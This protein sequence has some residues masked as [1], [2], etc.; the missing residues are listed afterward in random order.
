MSQNFILKVDFAYMIV[1]QASKFERQG[2]GQHNCFR[3]CE[4]FCEKPILHDFHG[5]CLR[6]VGHD[7]QE[8]S[9][10]LSLTQ[11]NKTMHLPTVGFPRAYHTKDS[12]SLLVTA[13]DKWM[14]NKTFPAFF[15]IRK[16]W[17]LRFWARA[18]MKYLCA[19]VHQ[20]LWRSDSTQLDPLGSISFSRFIWFI[21]TI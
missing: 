11:A 17:K 7:R 2:R 18:V 16:F 20:V 12:S 3:Q 15:C 1:G 5:I 9:K 19:C 10:C 6:F 13:L 4:N 14:S 8:R 21:D